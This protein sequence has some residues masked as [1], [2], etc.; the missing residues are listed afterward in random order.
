LLQLVQQP[1]ARS[2]VQQTAWLVDDGFV[3]TG[4]EAAAQR[5]REQFGCGLLPD[6]TDCAGIVGL[7]QL[8]A[9][10][11]P[12]LACA[13]TIVAPHTHWSPGDFIAEQYDGTRDLYLIG[14]NSVLPTP[15]AYPLAPISFVFHRGR[16][17]AYEWGD[18]SS[19][20]AAQ[21]DLNRFWS[22][23]TRLGEAVWEEFGAGFPLGVSSHH[24]F[25]ELW[26]VPEVGTLEA[27]APENPLYATITRA[28]K[29]PADGDNIVQVGWSAFVPEEYTPREAE[30]IA[31]LEAA[32]ADMSETDAGRAIR[33]L[34]QYVRGLTDVASHVV[35]G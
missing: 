19:M 15:P 11:D 29:N 23:L 13:V 20:S 5:I 3:S 7:R 31:K 14:P 21:N 22:D 33:E 26:E 6:G 24:R 1:Q 10:V 34:E 30:A 2:L 27:P 17:Y 9:K 18:Q 12:H 4:P 25:K 8:I 28:A 35:N 16:P 32:L